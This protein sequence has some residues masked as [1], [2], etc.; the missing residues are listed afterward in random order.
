MI[1]TVK[2]P[3]SD[4]IAFLKLAPKR[5]KALKKGS[6]EKLPET[7]AV[8]ILAHKLH[9]KTQILAISKIIE[10]NGART[11]VFEGE[12][13][14]FR[15]G[16]YVSVRLKIGSANLTRPYSISSGPGRPLEITIK[17]EEKGFASPW[18]LENWKIGDEIEISAPEGTFCYEPMRDEK[19]VVG[20]AGGSGITPFLSMA[21]A[22]RDGIEDF[23][24]TVLYGSR[25]KQAILFQTEL[26]EICAATDR[27]KVVYVLSDEKLDGYEHGFITADIIKK[28]SSDSS[29]V[30]LCGPGAMYH[31][32]DHELSKTGLDRKHIRHEL[33]GAPK[34]PE[35][36][37]GYT[38]D[39]QAEYRLTV[40]S[41][42]E[43]RVIPM[44]ACEP[45]LVAVERAGIEAPSR[46]RG[47]ECGW[48]RT[49]LISGEYFVPG[50]L[51]YRRAA[52]KKH[53]YIHLCSTFPLSDMEIV[54]P[55]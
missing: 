34:S 52:D 12:C 17:R 44:K 55:N 50:N 18:I 45:V 54:L 37:D 28:Y 1:K 13:A 5:R 42:N 2:N 43:T 23:D 16:Q 25:T 51:E 7:Y 46:C 36:I 26:D 49:R 32:V 11:Y 20:I 10:R 47:G 14:P 8:N 19:H 53:G 41:Y 24:L 15:A 38:G 31:F 21:A 30:F 29:S 40:H 6:E 9:P 4:L 33:F 22:V 3:V 35:G 39:F 48:C 27:V